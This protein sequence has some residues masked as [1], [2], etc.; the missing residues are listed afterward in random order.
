MAKKWRN[1]S[2]KDSDIN[3]EEFATKIAKAVA[4]EVAQEM[5]KS[6]PVMKKS[7]A[8]NSDVEPID[9]K[10]ELDE[11]VIPI[12]IDINN[13][14]ETNIKEKFKQE[15]SIDKG[16]QTSKDRLASIFK[17]RKQ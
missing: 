7:R 16:L 4:K 6:L 11:S 1:I 13:V 5:L 9:L 17:K 12:S 15:E 14:E 8:R 2:Y 10:V 3:L